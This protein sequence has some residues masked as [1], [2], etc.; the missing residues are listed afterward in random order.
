MFQTM[1]NSTFAGM[2]S[3]LLS[4]RSD[5]HLCIFLW[6]ALCFILKHLFLGILSRLLRES[7]RK[8]AIEYYSPCLA[9][10][11]YIGEKR[12]SSGI[13]SSSDIHEKPL[14]QDGDIE[15]D[16]FINYH[17]NED[18]A[19]RFVDNL[20]EVL[21]SCGVRAFVNSGEEKGALLDDM[22]KHV[23]SNA[24]LCLAI[25]SKEYAQSPKCLSELYEMV[26]NGKKVIPLFFDIEPSDARW[27]K[28]SYAEA[29]QRHGELK[30]FENEMVKWKDALHAASLIIGWELAQF[31]S[32]E[33]KLLKKVVQDVLKEVNKSPL[34][35]ARFPV[36]L[37]KR[38]EQLMTLLESNPDGNK[39]TV[40]GVVGMGGVGKTTL[41]KA[42][43]NQ[44]RSDFIATT[45][46]DVKELS[47]RHGLTALQE[48]ITRDLLDFDCKIRNVDEGKVLLRR[49]LN[50]A[51]GILVVLDNV[52]TFDQLEGLMVSEI[53][54]PS[55]RV[56]VTTRDKRIMELAQI[57]KIYEATR[58]N[59][60][61]ATELFSR[62]AFLSPR[63]SVGFDDLV[64]KFVEFL[65]GLP[66][67][68]E[69][70]GSYLYGKTERKE[71]EAI[72]RKISR[73]LPWNIKERLK[74]TLE[75]LDEEE[76][77]MFLDAACYLVREAKDTAIRIWDASGWSGWLGFE[78]LEQKCLIQVDHLDRITMHDHL[79]DI[80]KDMVD[81]ESKDFPGRRSR[82]WRPNDIIK[83]L[84]ENTGTEA[85]RGLSFASGSS[86]LSNN[87]E[88]GA[89]TTWQ[90]E[91][92]SQMNNLK[93]LVLEGSSF[94]GDFSKL[95]ENLLWL[96]WW[97]FPYQ[98]LPSNIPL[99]RLAVLDLARGRLITLWDEDYSQLPLNL[100]ELNLTD[101]NQLQRVPK[102]ISK[103]TVLQK[104]ILKGCRVLTTLP[105]EFSDLYFLEH[106]D[107][108]HC[109]RLLSLPTNFGRLKHLKHLDLSS[110]SKLKLLPDS[111]NQ[112]LQIK[113]LSFAKCKNLNIGSNILAMSSSL[114]YMDFQGCHKVQV[115]PCN[116]ASQRHLKWL[117]IQCKILKQLPEDL[118]ELI[119]LTVLTLH[120]PQITEIPESLGDL[121]HLEY[122]DVTSPG[123]LILPESIGRLEVLKELTIKARLLSYLPDSIGQLN[124][125]QSLFLV[126]CKALKNLPPSFENLVKLV[127]LDI[128]D[129]PNLRIHRGI[130]DGLRSLELLSLYR[131]KSLAD[132]SITSLC[133]NTPALRRVRLCKMILENCLRI[134]EHTS[135]RLQTLLFYACKNLVT[136]EICSTTLTV[137]ELKYCHELETISG[138]STSM[139]LTE[140]CLRNCEK[141]SKVTDLGAL[142]CLETLDISG[143]SRLFCI[144]VLNLFKQL[145]VLNISVIHETVQKQSEWLQKLPS[146]LELRI[147]ADSVFTNLSE[148]L[149][150]VLRPFQRMEKYKHGNG[151]QFTIPSDME[152][153]CGAVIIC[154]ATSHLVND[155]DD[156]E[157]ML[158]FFL[159][160]DKRVRPVTTWYTKNA[161]LIHLYIFSADNFWVRVMR[162][163]DVM[164]IKPDVQN[165]I[166]ISLGEGWAYMVPRGG[167]LDVENVRNAFLVDIGNG[168]IQ[169]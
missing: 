94:A 142:G 128:Y 140:L 27:I 38:V 52:D 109:T 143:C 105:Q 117:Y 133:E 95:P 39:A 99:G 40:V 108:S 125:L 87:N 34:E 71:W 37:S 82:L 9:S 73:I 132:G 149:S 6:V 46:L 107:M 16:V 19:N 23:I 58:L 72:L 51:T 141:L 54:G 83:A 61:E 65:D 44:I 47:E 90:A 81:Q 126:D 69:T 93:L 118:G 84:A 138:F 76:K 127:T 2:S 102:Y 121:I 163:G 26:Q 114:E 20:Y 97:D 106:L 42:T 43:Y 12:S 55:C 41:A 29:F 92:L 32:Q 24:T 152:M 103:M 18:S 36:G 3:G 122:L 68:L 30:K 91:S 88:S 151:L 157:I 104:V 146:P 120:C 150:H 98:C 134:P 100:L 144:E 119:R 15:Y 70:F 10:P 79:R 135:S 101:C 116:I 28:R 1:D 59:T 50:K 166:P 85:V 13:A 169:N 4:W 156:L 89:L 53:L 48:I 74:V 161:D 14:A 21:K 25:F 86:N 5:L 158:D 35:V 63:P 60:D 67:S 64:L 66:L 124:N 147:S 148:G 115:L 145:Q 139:R 113:F 123:L 131:C 80:G 136:V 164:I 129:A 78:T 111:F 159:E 57:S 137:V 33:G 56:L 75:G 160:H 110:C 22:T 167:E 49:R 77:S 8:D 154:F 17:K 130:L 7:L 165:Q 155:R 112:L 11:L 162:G 153:P 168:K 31:K 96:R 62:H 45:F